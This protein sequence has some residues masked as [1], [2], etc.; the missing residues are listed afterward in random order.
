ME[1][2]TEITVRLWDNLK[3]GRLGDNPLRKDSYK[4]IGIRL[5]NHMAQD[6]GTQRWLNQF[7]D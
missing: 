5:L 3:F 6:D 1:E 2:D 4:S 7:S